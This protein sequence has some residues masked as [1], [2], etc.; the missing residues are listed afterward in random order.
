[1]RF[2]TTCQISSFPLAFY[3]YSP[4]DTIHTYLPDMMYYLLPSSDMIPLLST[5]RQRH[6]PACLPA[7]IC[8]SASA[9]GYHLFGLYYIFS[10]VCFAFYGLFTGNEPH[11]YVPM[12]MSFLFLFPIGTWWR[13]FLRVTDTMMELEVTIL[14]R[15]SPMTPLVQTKDIVLQYFLILS[16]SRL[17]FLGCNGSDLKIMKCYC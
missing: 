8:L 2:S 12:M 16:T 7:S 5:Y 10:W 11:V 1:M 15:S 9:N 6:M 4:Y 17:P 14:V 3:N 13:F